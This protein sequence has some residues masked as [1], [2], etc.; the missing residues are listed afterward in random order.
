VFRGSVYSF[1]TLLYAIFVI[2][3]LLVEE[4]S[5][6]DAPENSNKFKSI[7]IFA[8]YMYLVG[9][10]FM[11][12]I[13]IFVIHPSWF[14]RLLCWLSENHIIAPASPNSAEVSSLYL[15]LGIVFFGSMG[16]VLF[17]LLLFLLFDGAIDDINVPASIGE[18]IL[19]LIFTFFQMYFMNANY[20]VLSVKY[21]I[22]EHCI[23]QLSIASSHNI[24]RFGFMHNFAVNVWTW[25]RF[26]SAKYQESAI[27]VCRR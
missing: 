13:S 15:R 3:F 22:E 9:I 1:A 18:A 19:G 6:S 14:N 11:L 7:S 16:V 17:G 23:F 10:G 24:C 2:I 26:T 21:S 27:H 4:I 5:F 12:Y 25:L 20:R 8:L